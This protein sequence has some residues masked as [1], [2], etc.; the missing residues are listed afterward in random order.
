MNDERNWE[1]IIEVVRALA[2]QH[3]VPIPEHLL[4]V[5]G[6]VW[7]RNYQ[8]R[9]SLNTFLAQITGMP[10]FAIESPL[11]EIADVLDLHILT[12]A[13]T[14]DTDTQ[15]R[16]PSRKKKEPPDGDELQS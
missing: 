3:H 14:P 2:E 9:V 13:T 4:V 11:D 10:E 8:K 15:T 7:E 12:E 16:K 1:R 6:S 5:S